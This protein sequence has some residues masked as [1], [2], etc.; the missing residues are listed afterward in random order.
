MLTPYNHFYQQRQNYHSSV[1][2]HF[3]NPRNVGSYDKSAIDVGTG[4]VGAPACGDVMKLQIKVE[5]DIIKDA[6]FRTFGCGSAIASSSLATEWI[7]GK[8][9]SDSLKIS[10]KDI[11]KKLSLP[12]VK[13]H[14]S[15]LAEDAIKAAISDYQK[16]NSL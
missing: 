11:A 8:S 9:I 3:E 10:N 14:C 13:L 7:K 16:K 12:P 4:L 1:I 2:D 6:K 15:M 5:N